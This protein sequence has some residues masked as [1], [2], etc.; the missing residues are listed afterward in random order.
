MR[1]RR[2]FVVLAVLVLASCA[3]P[4]PEVVKETV[5]VQQTVIVQQ[6]V[7]ATQDPLPTHTPYPTYTPQDPLPTYTPQ[8]PLP[9]YTPYPTYTVEP[10]ATEEPE[11]EVTNTPE[12]AEEPAL[13]VRRDVNIEQDR[14]GIVIRIKMIAIGDFAA[15]DTDVQEGLLMMSYW[16]DAK[17]IGGISIQVEN[18]TKKTA[19]LYP[20]QGTVVVGTEQIDVDLFSSD[21]VGGEIFAGVVKEGLIMFALKAVDISTVDTMR[22]IVSGPSDEEFSRLGEDYDFTI[23]L[24]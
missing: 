17:Y 8:D 5:V 24:R 22:Y 21:S 6:T 3:T 11:P 1:A 16:E 2:A 19:N 23:P 20:D 15:L 9:T 7:V 4:T 18:T 13:A 14:G 12:P 10:T